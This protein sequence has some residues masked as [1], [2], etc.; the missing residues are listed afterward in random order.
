MYT[1]QF[2]RRVDQISRFFFYVLIFWLPYSPAVVESCAVTMFVLWLVKRVVLYAVCSDKGV[3]WGERMRVFLLAFAPSKRVAGRRPM[4][5]FLVICILSAA[6]SPLPLESLSGFF[7]KTFEWFAVYFLAVE[8]LTARRH[9]F[10][11]LGVFCV[12]GLATALDSLLQF[13]WLGEDIFR[14]FPLDGGRRATGGFRYANQLGGYLSFL[15]PVGFAL[16]FGAGRHVNKWGRWFLGLMCVLALWALAVSFSRGAWLAVAGG[17]LFWGFQSRR[18][19][20]LRIGAG[21]LIAGIGI[22]LFLPREFKDDLRLGKKDWGNVTF[23]AEIWAD[24]VGMIADRPVFGHGPNLYMRIFQGYHRKYLGRFEHWPTYAHNGFLQV[25]AETGLLGGGVFL[26]FL[27]VVFR[28][29]FRTLRTLAQP[30]PD[31]AVLLGL[32]AGL[33]ASLLHNLVDTDLHTLQL[34]ILFWAVL[35]MMTAFDNI[36]QSGNSRAIVED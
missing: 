30:P 13:Y 25:T 15:I 8:V 6:N 20:A 35:G 22:A 33:T 4:G 26:F 29:A 34:G 21:L 11:A 24:T 16:F 3:R 5:V 2:V 32:Y 17:L 19:W 7:T 9:V 1:D 28:R 36:L 14:G 31:R 10:I 18:R 23:R 27:F 12:T